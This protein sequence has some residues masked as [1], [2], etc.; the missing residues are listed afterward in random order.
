MARPLTYIA[1]LLA[2]IAAVLYFSNLALDFLT[3]LIIMAIVLL[4]IGI[5]TGR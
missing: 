5:V 4:A 2:I 3:V 1:L